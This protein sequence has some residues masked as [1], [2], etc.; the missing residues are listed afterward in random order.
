MQTDT[1]VA[2][3]YESNVPGKFE[4]VQQLYADQSCNHFEVGWV[5][6]SFVVNK[7]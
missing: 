3:N 7:L 1:D 6:M 2:T 5:F 4:P